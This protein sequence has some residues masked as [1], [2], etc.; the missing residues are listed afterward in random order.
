MVLTGF[1]FSPTDEEIIEFLGQ[2]V[3]GNTAMAAFDFIIQ[4]NIYD[5][6]PQELHRPTSF[7]PFSVR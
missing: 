6:E 5:C 7:P 2:K 1:R 3:S 4:R